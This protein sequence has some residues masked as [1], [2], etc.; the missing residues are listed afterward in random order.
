LTT[1]GPRRW[2]NLLP[3]C[4]FQLRTFSRKTGAF[5]FV[6]PRKGIRPHR[7][8]FILPLER[9]CPGHARDSAVVSPYPF[10]SLLREPDS[11]SSQLPSSFS[12]NNCV[13]FPFSFWPSGKRFFFY[14]ELWRTGQF[15]LLFSITD[16]TKVGNVGA[17][18]S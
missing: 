8:R 15:S 12:C 11:F 9:A 17:A 3:P 10:Q 16:R 13:V 4:A 18:H 14:E 6:L 5:I 1:L 7:T 2:P